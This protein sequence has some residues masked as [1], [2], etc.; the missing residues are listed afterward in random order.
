L[1]Q[2]NND[3]KVRLAAAVVD[4]EGNEDDSGG[5][6][7]I[8]KVGMPLDIRYWEEPRSPIPPPP[9]LIPTFSLYFFLYL[10]VS[11]ATVIGILADFGR[12]K[13]GKERVSETKVTRQV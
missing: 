6:K 5:H 10:L 11:I 1:T 9:Y 7:K 2:A 8:S 4:D 12:R 3:A 13:N